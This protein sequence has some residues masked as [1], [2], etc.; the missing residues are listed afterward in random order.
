MFSPDEFIVCFNVN[1][2]VSIYIW[3]IEKAERQINVSRAIFC[4]LV[5]FGYVA[6]G[7]YVIEMHVCMDRSGSHWS[8]YSTFGSGRYSQKPSKLPTQGFTS[9]QWGAFYISGSLNL[10]LLFYVWVGEMDRRRAC[11][12]QGFLFL[13]GLFLFTV[14]PSP[15]LR[16]SNPA[17]ADEWWGDCVVFV[18]WG[19]ISPFLLTEPNFSRRNTPL[20][21]CHLI[22]GQTALKSNLGNRDFSL[23]SGHVT[24]TR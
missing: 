19:A 13:P 12:F 20:L 6:F 24:Q 18:S 5:L 11:S 10:S 22:Q 16:L 3:E 8:R 4:C 9:G 2:I 21:L 15:N 17:L 14:L 23:R 7:R 1:N